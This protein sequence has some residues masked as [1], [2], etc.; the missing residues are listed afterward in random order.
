MQVKYF[1][2]DG[3]E[4][5]EIPDEQTPQEVSREQEEPETEM[6][7]T[8]VQQAWLGLLFILIILSFIAAVFVWPVVNR[9]C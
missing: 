7:P 5:V 2:E 4:I 8:M 3:E 6:D 9:G 1:K